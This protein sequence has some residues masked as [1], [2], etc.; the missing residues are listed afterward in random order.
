M[1]SNRI[2]CYYETACLFLL[3]PE[4]AR[5][6]IG[7]HFNIF[8]SADNRDETIFREVFKRGIYEEFK[9]FLNSYAWTRGVQFTVY[10]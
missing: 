4:E 10:E 7:D 3:L 6:I 5:D 8:Y 1:E 9:R 2:K